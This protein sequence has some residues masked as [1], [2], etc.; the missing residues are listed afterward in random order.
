VH[1]TGGSLNPARSFG[2]CVATRSFPG[3]HWIYWVGPLLGATVASGLFYLFKFLHYETANPGQ[4]GEAPR[5]PY[6]EAE[7]LGSS[8]HK[9]P[10]F[11][12]GSVTSQA[13]GVM[14][15]SSRRYLYMPNPEPADVEIA[16]ARDTWQR[17]PGIEVTD[18]SPSLTRPGAMNGGHV[19]WRGYIPQSGHAIGS[20]AAPGQNQG[21]ERG[22]FARTLSSGV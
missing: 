16:M 14:S 19:A 9:Y 3:T 12:S 2:P 17:Q 6:T 7:R 1:W 5:G 13:G 10:D 11:S 4:D 22:R 8:I 15:D 21:N 18:A 20:N